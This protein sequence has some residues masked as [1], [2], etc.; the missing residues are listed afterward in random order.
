M[1]NTSRVILKWAIAFAV[2][3]A[4]FVIFLITHEFSSAEGL[5]EKYKLLADAFTI[6]GISLILVGALVWVSTEGLFDG[7]SYSLKYAGAMLLPFLKLKERH[8][9][10]YDYKMRKKDSRFKGYGFLF[11]VGGIFTAGAIVFTALFFTV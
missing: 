8:E 7:L 9:S 1:K 3:A 11:G 4:L 5:A 10:Y 6:P 2:A